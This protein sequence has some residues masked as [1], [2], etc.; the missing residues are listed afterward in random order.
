MRILLTGHKGYIGA[1]AGPILRSAGHEVVGLDTDLFAGCEFGEAAAEIPEVR[2]DIRDLT[3]A[4]LKRFD[5]V[6]HLAALS[7]DPLGDL[8]PELTYEINHRASVRL[9]QVARRV[10]VR[11]FLLASSCSNY[12][13][14]GN[15][16][17]VGRTV[18]G[19]R[20]EYASDA[21]PDKRSYRVSFEKIACLI[22]AFKPMWDVVK[23]AEQLYVSYCKSDLSREDFESPRYQRIGQIRKLLSEGLINAELRRGKSVRARECAAL[24]F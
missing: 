17:I 7:N 21:G 15:D 5:A 23:G 1:V 22:P 8:N 11:R 14:A 19:C 24:G 4:D 12:G 6:V 10:G 9:A 16:M 18:P 13:S 2:K 3:K 20:I